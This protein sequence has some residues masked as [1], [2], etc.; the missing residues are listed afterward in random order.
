[1]IIQ[2]SFGYIGS[3]V[4]KMS[5]KEAEMGYLHCA[6]FQY[7]LLV[8]CNGILFSHYVIASLLINNLGTGVHIFWRI[9]GSQRG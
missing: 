6:L 1:M 8:Y 9:R 2:I 3:S 7:P 5:I 4:L